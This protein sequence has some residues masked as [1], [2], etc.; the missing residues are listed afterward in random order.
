MR[1]VSNVSLS[2]VLAASAACASVPGRPPSLGPTYLYAA[3][4]G[5]PTLDSDDTGGNPFATALV[6]MLGRRAFTFAELRAGL[7]DITVDKSQGFQRPD[8][9]GQMPAEALLFQPALAAPRRV[10][11]VIVYSDYAAIAQLQV[12]PGAR[13]DAVRI[14]SALQQAGFSTTMLI[15]P[16][17][18]ALTSALSTFAEAS[19]TAAVAVVYATGHGVETRG[20]AYL[21]PGSFSLPAHGTVSLDDEAIA[22]HVLGAAMR[23]S[24]ANLLFYG[25]CRNNPMDMQ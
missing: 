20:K 21:L 17:R 22:I 12:L 7:V 10:A 19:S 13:F 11:L 5:Q 25:A 23:S 18:A 1:R 8:F 6:D 14:A 9:A 15:D 2:I 4:P 3:Q 16:T 24:Q